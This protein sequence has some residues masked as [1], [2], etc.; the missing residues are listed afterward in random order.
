MSTTTKAPRLTTCESRALAYC[1]RLRN[2]DG[3]TITVEWRK[4]Q[5]WG[6]NPVIE[7][8][9]GKCCN[10]SGSGYNKLSTALA[11][12]LKFLFP[13]GSPAFDAIA[14]L[15]GCGVS[16]VESKLTAHGWKLVQVANSKTVDVFTLSRAEVVA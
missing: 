1:N 8:Q 16:A 6:S 10:V 15:G 14:P 5:M 11:E 3:G 9:D 13:V 12:V 2:N 4:S 7:S